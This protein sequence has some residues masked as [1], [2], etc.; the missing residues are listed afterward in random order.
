MN[1]YVVYVYVY[2]YVISVNIEVWSY[3][4]M[5]DTCVVCI[6]IWIMCGVYE[7]VC[8]IVVYEDMYVYIVYI[9]IE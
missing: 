8:Y 9:Y 2:I 3:L 6:Y 7:Y 4:C 5:Y 1:W